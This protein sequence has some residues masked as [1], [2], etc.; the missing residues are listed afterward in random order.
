MILVDKSHAH[1]ERLEWASYGPRGVYGSLEWPSQVD[2][3]RIIDS[4]RII[5][6]NDKVLVV[7]HPLLE[8]SLTLEGRGEIRLEVSAGLIRIQ[9]EDIDFKVGEV[10]TL[11][12][13]ESGAPYE[14]KE[15]SDIYGYGIPDLVQALQL[16]V[17]QP[18]KLPESDLNNNR[19]LNLLNALEAWNAG[20]DGSGVK[21]AV[22]D[23]G[24]ANHPEVTPVLKR[25]F[26][27]EDENAEN[28]NF[29]HH[30]LK[31]ASVIAGKQE[32]KTTKDIT[33]IAHGAEIIDLHVFGG[34][35]RSRGLMNDAIIYAVDNGASIIQI[36]LN[37]TADEDFAT[38]M[39][40]GLEYA[41]N[42][43][44]LISIAAGNSGNSSPRGL[45]D[46]ALHGY[47]VIIGG[48]L[49]GDTL[50]PA[51]YTNLAGDQIAAF[52]FA[53]SGGWYPDENDGYVESDGTSL[54]SPYLAGIAA[55]L[56]QKWPDIT[57]GEIIDILADS[58]SI[59]KY[60]ATRSISWL[61][62]SYEG[63]RNDVQGTSV[64]E[65][66]LMPGYSDY[67]G[68]LRF[69]RNPE[70][71]VTPPVDFSDYDSFEIETFRFLDGVLV[72]SVND[73][74]VDD[75][76]QLINAYAGGELFTDRT[77]VGYVIDIMENMEKD[78]APWFINEYLFGQREDLM[79][80]LLLAT[81]NI[82]GVD[83]EAAEE[84]LLDL[85]EE[86]GMTA[87]QTFWFI[88]ESETANEQVRL[89]ADFEYGMIWYDDVSLI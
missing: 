75:S 39:Q 16:D 63:F 5:N 58:S 13:P 72:S 54:S 60:G 43:N 15:W 77:I 22:L 65:I 44:V 24:I 9:G 73:L 89:H 59:P 47:P 69:P 7:S 48:S 31:V 56:Y 83:A 78:E 88:A 64:R 71:Y 80:S 25:H 18:E 79:P 36:S 3:N 6:E 76:L 26:S 42:N 62:G 41:A 27:S 37:I 28:E 87:A 53:P 70:S 11:V 34:P 23:F 81:E 46:L 38:A 61:E 17:D 33:G 2:S 50:K 85:M 74:I 8:E 30:G 84:L 14:I 67:E 10:S 21:V 1:Y 68:F 4:V 45:E 52:F 32:S 12:I 20:Y 35:I 82:F 29:S 19:A 55:L 86:T 49:A 40:V 57:P 66:L 51:G